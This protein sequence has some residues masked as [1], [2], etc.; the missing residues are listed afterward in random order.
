MGQ[1]S[2][3][4]EDVVLGDD[5]YW[6]RWMLPR[7][8]NCKLAVLT[9]YCRV[10][11]HIAE[12]VPGPPDGTGASEGDDVVG[13]DGELV[14]VP[15][16]L[17]LQRVGGIQQPERCPDADGPRGQPEQATHGVL[18]RRSIYRVRRCA[19]PVPHRLFLR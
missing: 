18:L 2:A 9:D 16:A 5:V 6:R 7:S 19:C 8:E 10:D 15:A 13:D 12:V 1:A 3:Q 14:D 11:N 4:A 17:C